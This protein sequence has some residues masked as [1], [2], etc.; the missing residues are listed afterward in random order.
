V[1]ASFFS[2]AP[3]IESYCFIF[4]SLAT[5][6]ESYCFIFTS[7]APTIV[8]EILSNGNTISYEDCFYYLFSIDYINS[9]LERLQWKA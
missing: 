1:T 3:T 5:A 9:L 8:V 7:L 4:N 2:L 6:I